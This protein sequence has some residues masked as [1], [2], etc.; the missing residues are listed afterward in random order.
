MSRLDWKKGRFDVNKETNEIQEA[1]RG[2]QGAQVGDAVLWFRFESEA[3]VTNDVYDEGSGVGRVFRPPV[4]VPTLHVT[5]NEGSTENRDTGFYFNDDLHFTASLSQ[6]ART[7]L[8]FADIS[9]QSYLKDRVQYD[10]KLFRITNIQVLVQI[11]QRDL[12]LSVEATQLKPDE[13]VNDEQF[14]NFAVTDSVTSRG[15]G[16]V[17]FPIPGGYGPYSRVL[18]IEPGQPVPAG[19]PAGTIIVEKEL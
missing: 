19:T 6:V 16:Y 15:V 1:L 17:S 7:G 18:L 11:Q 4:P 13:L 8:T 3:S 14:A 5:H 2:H 10:N 9:H 12:I